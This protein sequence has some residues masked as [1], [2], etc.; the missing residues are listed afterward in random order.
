MCGVIKTLGNCFFFAKIYEVN[1]VTRVQD[2]GKKMSPIIK[3]DDVN[4]P[5][6]E[7][8]L[9]AVARRPF[10][11]PPEWPIR[12]KEYLDVDSRSQTCGSKNASQSE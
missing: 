2:K 6:D 3:G 10:R 12:V 9:A 1:S 5:D 11:P 4:L 7:V 8:L